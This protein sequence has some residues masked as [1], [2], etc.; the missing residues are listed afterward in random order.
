[1]LAVQLE[2]DRVEKTLRLA[3]GGAGSDD[4]VPT[5]H[6]RGAH[7]EFLMDVQRAVEQRR[8]KLCTCV[9]KTLLR[10]G[11]CVQPLFEAVRRFFIRTL[12]Q[13]AFF[14]QGRLERM[15]KVGILEVERCLQVMFVTLANRVGPPFDVVSVR[16]LSTS[17]LRLC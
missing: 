3:A 6:V 16:Y 1:M 11:S 2:Q 4:D 8:E 13:T 14:L 12:Q 9:G 7:C 10:Q 5:I 17:R 15:P